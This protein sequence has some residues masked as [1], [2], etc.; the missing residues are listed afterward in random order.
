VRLENLV[1]EGDLGLLWEDEDD[2]HHIDDIVDAVSERFGFGTVQ[3]ASLV[4]P[5]RPSPPA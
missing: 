2:G 3:A 4:R 1:G 5:K